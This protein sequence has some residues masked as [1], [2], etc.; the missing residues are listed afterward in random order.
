MFQTVCVWRLVMVGLSAAAAAGSAVAL[1]MQVLQV[2]GGKGGL[3]FAWINGPRGAAC[4]RKA[5]S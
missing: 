4:S 5:E 2:L 1:I 3:F